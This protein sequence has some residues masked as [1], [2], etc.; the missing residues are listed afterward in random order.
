[1]ASNASSLLSRPWVLVTTGFI[2]AY[3]SYVIWSNWP[4]H[5]APSS[6]RRRN[7][8]RSRVNTRPQTRIWTSDSSEPS[9]PFGLVHVDFDGI[10][11]RFPN[12]PEPPTVVEI[13]EALNI[14]SHAAYDVT[15]KIQETALKHIFSI[16]ARPVEEQTT[17]Q[18]DAARD[19]QELVPFLRQPNIN[20]LIA[21]IHILCS[22]PW[23]FHQAAAARAFAEHCGLERMPLIPDH[24]DLAMTEA[25]ANSDHEDDG[26][27]AQGIK[28]VVY[29]IAEEK[30]M[31]QLYVHTGIRCEQCGQCPILGVRWH[32]NNCPDFD[33]CSTCETQPMHPKTHVFTKIKIPIS[34]LG[35]NH[36]VQDVS[37]PGDPLAQW[38]ALRT[39]LKKELAADSGFED[40]EI[41]VF[42][43]QF[44]CKANVAYPEDPMQI[45]LAID[46]HAFNKLM[47]SPTWKRPAEP[48]ILYDRMFSFYDTDN[49]GLIGFK[50]YV[51]GIA[52]LRRPNKQSSLERVFLGYD[53]D[54]DG[55]ISRRDF[56]RMLSAKYAIQKKLV[57]DTIRAAE[58]D[59][60]TYT[61]NIVRSSQPISA[62]FAQ[63]D[64]PPGQTRLPTMKLTDRFGES[65]VRPDGG[66]FASAVLPDG[67]ELPD[68]GLVGAIAHRYGVDALPG[69]INQTDTLSVE[70]LTAF[71]NSLNRS[72]SV[73][74]DAIPD[75]EESRFMVD[76]DFRQIRNQSSPDEP[77]QRWHQDL[78]DAAG[79]EHSAV[80]RASVQET[81]SD[82]EDLLPPL[83][84]DILERGRA[85]EVPAAEKDFGS[86]VI[87]Q[88]VQ[89]GLNELI[90]PIFAKKE[91]IAE[92][93][94]LT[95]EERRRFRQEIDEYVEE[96]KS[97][98]EELIAGS[99]VD[100]LMAIANAANNT[101]HG[102]HERRHDSGTLDTLL[103]VEPT[104]A[105]A[106]LPT[107]RE[108]AMD[109]QEHI[110]QQSQALDDN[111]E[112]L[113]SSIREQSLDDLLA[114]SGY[115]V[116]FSS[117]AASVPT[118]Q[119]DG[120]GSDTNE[121]QP[122]TLDD[123]LADLPA[124]EDI[125]V[126][127]N[128]DLHHAETLT[129][130]TNYS[131]PT[132]HLQAPFSTPDMD[133][134]ASVF[135]PFQSDAVE[136]SDSPSQERLRELARLDEEEKDIYVRG[137]PGRL[138]LEEFEQIIRSD[139]RGML[140]GVAEAWLEWAE[141]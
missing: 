1:M 17:E 93:V 20:E 140:Q 40:L 121:H 58:I 89:E 118:T 69:N 49:N 33:L 112:N 80:R 42:Y 79:G 2:A 56:I 101:D 135:A 23:R 97:R 84:A 116:D 59:M 128:H 37:Y 45:G 110:V 141:F 71:T 21:R 120:A 41:Q 130:S 46:R 90:D 26:E 64:V 48:N 96:A 53:F 51:L 60:V 126:D 61:S 102:S 77:E 32:C 87:F 75:E 62:A 85:Y 66:P 81:L 39:S 35:Q 72:D 3:T 119:L 28:A 55:Y 138:N 104:D 122:S 131:P 54:G 117:D 65:Q 107:P 106:R 74:I 67:L 19:L 14:P 38:P 5:E 6:L 86:E 132:Q 18:S 125:P 94:R 115:I 30:T 91:R 10:V 63:E 88:V 103:H 136:Q 133:S 50:E 57:E 76:T 9:L 15:L 11:V 22:G 8:V 31:R 7:A 95:Q 68:S 137:G 98:R 78:A 111:L 52:Y 123:M 25:A 12:G 36:Q 124:L 82:S 70:Q 139:K 100:P 43:D 29:H 129:H 83:P 16:L 34:F 92:Q 134:S 13:A 73:A 127:E 108:I 44:G 109:L 114:Q 105:G 27:P 113:E 99:E 4:A 47:M 24:A